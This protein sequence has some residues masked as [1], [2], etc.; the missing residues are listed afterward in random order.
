MQVTDAQ[1]VASSNFDVHFYRCEWQV[2]PAVRFIKG[3]VHTYFTI[4]ETT[5]SITFDLARALTVD[6]VLYHHTK[7]DFQQ[8]AT[9]A[10]Q[11]AFPVT[12]E[13]GQQDSVAIYYKGVPSESGFGSFTQTTHAGTPVLWTL[14]EPY[15]AREWWP[16]K[17]NLTD[18]ADSIDMALTY[19]ARYTSSANGIIVSEQLTGATKQAFWKHRYPIAS[20]L[21]AMAITNYTINRDSVELPSGQ[22]PVDL[23]AYP[24]NAEQF[25]TATITAKTALQTYSALLGEYPFRNERY[26]QTQFSWGGGMEHQTN[27]FI[28]APDQRLV[29]HELSHQWFGDKVT[30]GSWQHLWLN[31]GFA[32]YME[33]VFTEAG[34]HVSGI[35]L[36][37]KWQNSITAA[38]GGAVFITDTANVNR[39]FDARLTYNKGA[40]VLH[41]LRWKLGDSVFF[42]GLRQYL[43]DPAISYKL[44]RTEDL[45]R[46][47]E[48]VSGQS[49]APFFN[50]WIYS[51]GFPTYKAEWNNTTGNSVRMILSQTTSHPSIGFYEMPVPVQFKNATRDTILVLNHMV[52][53]EGFTV[54][55][56][57]VA[58]TVIIDPELHILSKGNLAVKNSVITAVPGAPEQTEIWVF[59][60]PSHSQVMV[61]LPTAPAQKSLLQ[62]YTA[63]GQ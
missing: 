45:Q 12:L 46:N 23:Y 62:L 47:L 24:E 48:A 41:M 27:S 51:E 39:L 30:T 58:D 10:L 31:E 37:Q 54:D 53:N 5:R 7:L 42:R 13:V 25:K 38:P 43:A 50:E 59:P 16:C 29:A 49:L 14:S 3:A 40:Y 15:G 36:L 11:V 63:A 52:N 21:V 2:D 56:G 6:S 26:A 17:D 34:L 1:S 28:T 8:L 9:N 60:N 57:F 44:A 22:M 32:T 19:P 35:G 4:T 33:L 55:P 18:K 20:Y 61:Q